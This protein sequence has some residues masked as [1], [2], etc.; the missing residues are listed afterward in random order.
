MEVALKPI[1]WVRAQRAAPEDDYWG[2]STARIQLADEFEPES[3][4]GLDAFSHVEVVYLFDRVTPEAIVRGARHPRG[5]SAWPRVGIFAQR[6]KNRP[7]R[8][9]TCV[10][11]IVKVVGRE[12]TVAEL[13]AIDGTPVLDL[14]PVMREF[15]PRTEITQP[16]WASELMAHYWDAGEE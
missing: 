6:A 5:N 3:L 15:L 10:V 2:G 11:R 1:G 13:D 12:L 7:N 8:I 4:L 14:K 16:S 9:G